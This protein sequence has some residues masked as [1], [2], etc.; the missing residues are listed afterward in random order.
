MCSKQAGGCFLV[1][2]AT[3][4]IQKLCIQNKPEA[5]F[6]FLVTFLIRKS[7]V[8]TPKMFYYEFDCVFKLLK[9]FYYEFY[10]NFREGRSLVCLAN[11]IKLL[12]TAD[13]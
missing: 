11:Y 7:C 10:K 5:A 13:F 2:Y 6:N 12:L 8:Q 1:Y 4:L 9:C 3:F